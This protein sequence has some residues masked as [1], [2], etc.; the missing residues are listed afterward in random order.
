MK[1]KGIFEV[2]VSKIEVIQ[3]LLP[4]IYN[5]TIEE[6]V[7]EYQ[8]AMEAGEQFPPIVVWDKGN[9]IY[10]LI[11]G[12][13]R[14]L[15]CR[16]LGKEVIKTEV[17]EL[18]DE[19]EARML[20]IE[21]NMLHGIPL[22]REEK[23]ELAR[24]LYA[25]GVEIEKLRRLFR[26]S[27]RTIYNWVQG[28]KR[29]AKDEELKRQ[30][31]ELRKQ[32]LSQQEVAERL[33]VTKMA[34]SNW[35]RESKQ[36]AKIA[37]SLLANN[38]QLLTPDGTPTPEGYRLLSAFIEEHEEAIKQKSFNEVVKEQALRDI[39]K[40]LNETVKK[41]FRRF[42]DDPYE[43]VRS[44][45]QGMPPYDNLSVRA[46]RIFFDKA[47]A[48]FEEMKK[49]H[50][51]RR[52][53]KE[54]VLE[55]AKEILLDPEYVFST[56]KSLRFEL[57]R[58][59]VDIF[60]HEEL[61]D[62]ILHQHADELLAVYKQ[63]PEPAE[64]SLSEEEINKIKEEVK[65]EKD[66]WAR[67]SKTRKAVKRILREKGLRLVDSVVE[68]VVKK[69]EELIRQEE[70]EKLEQIAKEIEETTP[71]E[72]WEA[73]REDFEK[74][75]GKKAQEE[76]KKPKAKEKQEKSLP[77]SIEDWYRNALEELLLDM[78]I[79]LGWV[80]AFEIADEIYQKV[81]EYSK[82]AVRGW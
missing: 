31:L 49:E 28:V 66:R 13:H 23:K 42:I 62:E 9:G 6:K 52:K 63:I 79:K 33:G 26:I 29:R 59:G 24:L 78:G 48:V 61:V 74:A 54:V 67:E 50:E 11:D 12:M 17:V 76:E 44:Y 68:R 56:W 30:A 37:D 25:D 34:I 39:L 64:D 3:G 72:T 14:L 16:R 73:L 58:R 57:G 36:P 82:K 47:Q 15:A 19:V 51:E 1:S 53:L 65:G 77:P 75:F 27:E 45:L 22:S 32:G 43:K 21:K 4:R 8:E 2:P 60:G 38:S 7:Q 55:K 70:W 69:V 5:H 10:W 71:E 41:D 80:R 46:R 81:K 40:F 18:T 35:E 20:A